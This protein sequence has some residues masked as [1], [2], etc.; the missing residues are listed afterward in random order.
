MPLPHAAFE[1]FSHAA[2]TDY[3]QLASQIAMRAATPYAAADSR[4]V[5]DRY[6]CFFR[7]ARLLMVPVAATS[8][9]ISS[10]MIDFRHGH[11]DRRQLAPVC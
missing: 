6:I 11:G 5:A 10:K 9:A 1:A 7:Y 2:D 8:Y 3:F 4:T